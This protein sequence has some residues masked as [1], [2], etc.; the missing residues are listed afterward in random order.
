[1]KKIKQRTVAVLI[2]LVFL[3]FGMGVYLSRYISNGDD[4]TSFP[5]NRHA[6]TNGELAV[7]SILDRNGV[8]LSEASGSKRVFNKSKA[9]RLSV[10][11]TVGD[12]AGYIG[13]G[14]LAK[15]KPLLMGYNPITGVTLTGKSGIGPAAGSTKGNK[16]YLTLDSEICSAAYKA[17]DGRN[18]AVLVSN[19][20]TGEILCMVSAPGFDPADPPVVNEDDSGYEG[21]Y[22]NKALSS[23]FVPGS[24]FKLVTTAAAIEHIDDLYELEF[25]CEG[26]KFI[27][28]DKIVCEGVHGTIN[29]E[30]ALAVSCNIAYAE[31]SQKLGGE[32]LKEYADKFGLTSGFSVNGIKTAAGYFEIAADGTADLSWSGIGQYTDLVNPCG[33]LKLMGAIA[34]NGKAVTPRILKKATT[35][36]GLP[37]GLWFP[38][39][40]RLMSAETAVALSDM[41]RYNVTSVYGDKNFPGLDICAKTGTAQVGDGKKPHA[42][43]VGF[44]RNEE[45][46]YAFTVLVENGGSGRTV[47][48]SVANKV[49]QAAVKG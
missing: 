30:D 9:V 27:G 32:R 48:G 23:K 33:M 47:A 24:I 7:G 2:L 10:V 5:V 8:I 15:F 17:L 12:A 1:M 16:L 21:I 18:G 42:W 34:N 35:S 11:H 29:I 22:I 38:R 28:G 20:K 44:L 45:F 25:T 13:T 40:E 37:I 14:V 49:L 6:F 4:W 46:P 3:G 19:Y 36:G 31:L 41:M 39:S 43:F 26:E